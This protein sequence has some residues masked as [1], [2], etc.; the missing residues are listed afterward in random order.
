MATAVMAS[1]EEGSRR[2]KK[3]SGS[4][5]DSTAVSRMANASQKPSSSKR[6][7]NA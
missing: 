1:T 3:S 2:A 5:A 7:T 4:A 6:S